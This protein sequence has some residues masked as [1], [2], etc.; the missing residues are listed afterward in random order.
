MRETPYTLWS[1][2]CLVVGYGRCGKV[3]GRRLAALGADVTATARSPSDLTWIRADG[4]NSLATAD[5]PARAGEFDIIFNTVPAP[6]FGRNALAAVKDP[7]EKLI[8]DLA[9]TPGV[10][11]DAAREF[12]MKAFHALSLPGKVAP[13][14]AAQI[15]AHVVGRMMEEFL[16]APEHPKI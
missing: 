11:L 9:S 13:K 12:G 8:V 16:I 5:V 10:D 14:T 1:S 6:V 3:L 2:R 7:R 15:I 4:L